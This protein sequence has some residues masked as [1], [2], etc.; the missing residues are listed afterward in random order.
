MKNI[1]FRDST[2]KPLTENTFTREGYT[3]LGWNTKADGTGTS[4]EDKAEFSL[5]DAEA[6]ATIT[7]YA[8][9]IEVVTLTAKADPYT[10]GAYYTTF[11]DSS[12]NYAVDKDTEAYYVETTKTA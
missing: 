8:Q 2:A 12:V 1:Y 5:S 4:Y 7:L 10:K 11:Y 9:W 3:F 6:G